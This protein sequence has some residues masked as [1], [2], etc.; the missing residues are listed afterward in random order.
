MVQVFCLL[1][2]EITN[3]PGGFRLYD[4]DNNINLYGAILISTL[5]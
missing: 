2:T 4:N 5:P 1:K 3:F